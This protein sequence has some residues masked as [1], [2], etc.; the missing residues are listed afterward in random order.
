MSGKPKKR[1]GDAESPE[2]DR[3]MGRAV[4]VPPKRIYCISPEKM[5]G[6]EA[7]FSL[8]EGLFFRELC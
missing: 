7:T 3:Q 1:N 2:N 4:S 8:G 5:G 6:S